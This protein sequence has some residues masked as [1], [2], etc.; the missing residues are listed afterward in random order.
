MPTP[1]LETIKYLDVFSQTIASS[2]FSNKKQLE[3]KKVIFWKLICKPENLKSTFKQ[4]K[5]I[6]Q[7]NNNQSNEFP[8]YVLAV[9]LKHLKLNA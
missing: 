7:T 6:F 3:V 5:N 2:T 9:Y 1:T 4:L 8:T